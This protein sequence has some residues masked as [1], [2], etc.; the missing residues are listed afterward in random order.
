M[1][2]KTSQKRVRDHP[3]EQESNGWTFGYQ[4]NWKTGK[5]IRNL[6]PTNKGPTG[7][8]IE[9]D[10]AF[11]ILRPIQKQTDERLPRESNREPKTRSDPYKTQPIIETSESNGFG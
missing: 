2:P 9:T 1:S 7:I 11:T 8:W 4:N 5:I 10:G 3:I 6:K